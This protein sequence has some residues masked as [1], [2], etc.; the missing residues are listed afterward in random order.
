M[1]QPVIGV[2][3]S[4]DVQASQYTVHTDHTKALIEAGGKPLVIPYEVSAEQIAFKLDGLYL[5]GGGDIEPMLFGEQP[6]PELRPI[7]KVRDSYEIRFIHRIIEWKKP[8]FAVCRG[9]QILNVALGGDMYQDM[10]SQIKTELIQHEQNAIK[11][12]ASHD[13][14]VERDS[15][16]YT[17]VQNKTIRVNSRHHQANRTVAESLKVSATAP[18]GVIEAVES[19]DDSFILGV[20]WHPENLAVRGDPYAKKLYE[21][22]VQACM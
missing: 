2:I 22:F 5:T 18:D 6:I 13:I 17:I 10:Y 7:T 16:L 14:S 20:Q 15:L 19:V 12:Y 3:P 11:S 1:E 9:A 21:H 8:I 4:L